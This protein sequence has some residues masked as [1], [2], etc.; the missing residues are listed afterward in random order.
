MIQMRENRYD[1]IRKDVVNR[2][3]ETKVSEGSD[4]LPISSAKSRDD[5]KVDSRINKADD[6]LNEE[7]NSW[8]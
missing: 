5:L 2:S 3:E 8:S 1:D 6:Y 7:Y 4:R